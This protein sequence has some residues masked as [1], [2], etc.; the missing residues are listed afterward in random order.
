M[1]VLSEII[2][3]VIAVIHTLFHSFPTTKHFITLQQF[4]CNNERLMHIV[5]YFQGNFVVIRNDK[6]RLLYND[7][8]NCGSDDEDDGAGKALCCIVMAVVADLSV[9]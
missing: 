9:T 6:N 3:T 7:D 8:D 2:I 5:H 4:I 1:L